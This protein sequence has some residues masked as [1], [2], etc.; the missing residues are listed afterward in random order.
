MFASACG[1]VTEPEF[2]NRQT[3]E[4]GWLDTYYGWFV[5][6]VDGWLAGEE[7]NGSE[8]D[9]DPGNCPRKFPYLGRN[10]WLEIQNIGQLQFYFKGPFDRV[11]PPLTPNR[12]KYSAYGNIGQSVDGEWI[13]EGPLIMECR[14]VGRHSEF[15]LILQRSSDSRVHSST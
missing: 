5:S 4:V 9:G 14:R 2:V 11:G 12:A 3:D 7:H 6:D 1:E 8:D 15:T 13:A 10:V